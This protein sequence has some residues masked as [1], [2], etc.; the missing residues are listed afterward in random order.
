[1][2]LSRRF[3]NANAALRLFTAFDPLDHRLDHRAPARS[4]AATT[5]ARSRRRPTPRR[6]AARV[7][8][9]IGRKMAT[10]PEFACI[11]CKD[12]LRLQEFEVA[13]IRC[14]F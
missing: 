10:M 3:S 4:V 1:M 8:I 13:G 9:P 5:Y 14:L 12:A 6:A 7:L 11:A 2:V